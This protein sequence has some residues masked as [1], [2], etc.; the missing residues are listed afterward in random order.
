M[1]ATSTVKA[2]QWDR[3]RK[4]ISL[5]LAGLDRGSIKGL[6]LDIVLTVEKITTGFKSRSWLVSSLGLLPFH[7]PNLTQPNLTLPNLQSKYSVNFLPAFFRHPIITRVVCEKTIMMIII[8]NSLNLRG[9]YSHPFRLDEDF[10]REME[11]GWKKETILGLKRT[12]HS[13]KPRQ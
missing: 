1:Y 3:S 11:R 7:A 5:S 4:G 12:L 13:A 10:R 9:E 8:I 2:L 6:D